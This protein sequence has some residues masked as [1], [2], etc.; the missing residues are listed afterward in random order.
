MIHIGKQIQAK[1]LEQERTPGWLA[2]KINCDHTNIYKIFRRASIDTEL[3]GRISLA[4][5]HD[6]FMELSEEQ[7]DNCDKK[8]TK[9]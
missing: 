9:A 7:N 4:L 6:F 3:L 2:R 1:L 8:A 5:G